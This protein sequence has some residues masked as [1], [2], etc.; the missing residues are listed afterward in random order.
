MD[1]FMETMGSRFWGNL[2]SA[3]SR[4]RATAKSQVSP[5]EAQEHL[6]VRRFGRV[7]HVCELL[8]DLPS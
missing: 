6:N 3:S 7:W 1:F 5:A 4:N 8:H 2:S